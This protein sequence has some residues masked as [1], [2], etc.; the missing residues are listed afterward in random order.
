MGSANRWRQAVV[1]LHILTSVGWMAQA[2]TLLTLMAVGGDGATRVSAM[3]MAH[4]LDLR[5]LAPMA[6]ASAVTGFLLAAATPW[7]YF[8][9]WW[10]LGKF[11]I[12]VVQL[13]AGIFLLSPALR[14]AE[15]A[16]RAGDPLPAPWLR[17]AGTAFMT[18]A[19]AF[20]AWLSVS[21]PRRQTSWAGPAKPPLASAPVFV[22]AF[23][24]P[25]IDIGVGMAL[26]F[27]LPVLSVVVLV[28]R[29]VRRRR[30]M[31][32]AQPSPGRV[33]PVS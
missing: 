7:G 18:G 13:N 17:M 22:A 26:G 28:V 12:T 14:A 11:A 6:N 32:N 33:S 9:H 10:V 5:L 25:L 2:L 16:A 29:L 31:A 1:W 23:W 19:I 24:A 15:E 20:Q 27:P 30:E 3:S 4:V 21:K 8:R